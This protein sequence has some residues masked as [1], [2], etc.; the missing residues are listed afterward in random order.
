MEICIN[1]AGLQGRRTAGPQDRRAA[2]PQGRRTT[3]GP[4]DRRVAGPQDRSRRDRVAELQSDRVIRDQEAG[5]LI[6]INY[7]NTATLRPCGPM[8]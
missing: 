3:A 8:F 4:Q 7:C 6:Q 1:N 2:G 5:F